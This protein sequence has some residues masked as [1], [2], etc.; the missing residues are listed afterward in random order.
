MGKFMSGMTAGALFGAA[1]G[2]VIISQMDRKTQRMI[3]R[4]GK[5]MINSM[6]GTYD[7]MMHWMK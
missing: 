3:R 2:T 5:K 6:S 1:V 4:T 7:G